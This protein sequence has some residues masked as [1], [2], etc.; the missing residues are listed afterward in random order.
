MSFGKGLN[1]DQS[2]MLSSGK[3]WIHAWV[4]TMRHGSQMKEVM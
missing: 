4:Q 1:L 3:E 2:K